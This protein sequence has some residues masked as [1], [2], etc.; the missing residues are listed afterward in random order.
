M[1]SCPC[2]S[3]GT[4]R[5]SLLLLL[6]LFVLFAPALC[7]AASCKAQDKVELFGGYSYFRASIRE[8]QFNPCVDFCPNL[9]FSTSHANLNGWN[10]S[11]QYKFLPFLGAVADFNGIYGTTNGAGAR[12][13][14][15]LFGPQV[16][17][18][19]KVSPFVHAL[20][21]AAIESQDPRGVCAA[22]TSITCPF[23]LGSDASFATAIGA[24]FDIKLAPLVKLRLFQVDYLRTQLH[25]ATQNQARAS[26]GIVFHF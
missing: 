3:A 19:T 8:G 11:M 1:R 6:K 23:T 20:F 12:E 5:F 25:G 4:S 7:I 16:S 21:G 13:H 22:I 2:P 24:G 9:T 10:L 18:P 15:F 26:A 14:T 17:L